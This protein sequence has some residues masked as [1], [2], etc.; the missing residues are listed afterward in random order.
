MNVL[1]CSKPNVV[2]NQTVMS[3][4]RLNELPHTHQNSPSPLMRPTFKRSSGGNESH[5][6]EP[7]DQAPT[8]PTRADGQRLRTRTRRTRRAPETSVSR[9]LRQSVRPN[10]CPGTNPCGSTKP[11]LGVPFVWKKKT[12]QAQEAIECNAVL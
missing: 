9:S 11:W 10:A 12:F 7:S 5:S 4:S 3:S 1:V 6:E 2:F 8:Q